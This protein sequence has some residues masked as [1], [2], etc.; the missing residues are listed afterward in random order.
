MSP[1]AHV[2]LF[3]MLWHPPAFLQGERAAKAARRAHRHGQ[4]GLG[5]TIAAAL[6]PSRNCILMTLMLMIAL[7]QVLA[8]LDSLLWSGRGRR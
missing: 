6:K 3:L 5:A 7:A 8:I 1:D 4:H 2:I